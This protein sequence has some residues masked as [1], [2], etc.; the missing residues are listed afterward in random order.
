MTTKFENG[1][2][3]FRRD[4]RI[5]DNNAL[6]LLNERCDKVFTIFIF[7]PEQVGSGN[8]YKSDNSVQFMIE[9]LQ[10]L[11]GQISRAGGHLYTFFGHNDEIVEH[12]RVL[13][14]VAIAFLSHNRHPEVRI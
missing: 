12:K 7:T 6:N 10:D 4:F 8:K 13:I 5:I 2:F 1:L 9:S 14:T 3:I 11:A